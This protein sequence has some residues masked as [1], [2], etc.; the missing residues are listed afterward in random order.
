MGTKG[1]RTGGDRRADVVD[2][3]TPSATGGHTGAWTVP[4]VEIPGRVALRV[5]RVRQAAS[6]RVDLGEEREQR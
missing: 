6:A 4:E 1:E 5:L 2:T 3:S